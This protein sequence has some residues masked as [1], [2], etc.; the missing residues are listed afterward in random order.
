MK[1]EELRIGNFIIVSNPSSPIYLS[2]KPTV[3]ICNYHHISDICKGDEDWVYEPVPLTEQWLIDFGFVK[4]SVSDAYNSHHL[5][6][7][8]EDGSFWSDVITFGLEIKHVH[9]LQNLF[10]AITG[11]ELDYKSN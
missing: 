10:F 1:A 8:K 3:E 7:Y 5:T 6:I 4:C 9:Q 11:E 2:K